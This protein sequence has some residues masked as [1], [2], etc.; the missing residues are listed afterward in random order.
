LSITNVAKSQQH[1]IRF[2]SFRRIPS[3]GQGAVWKIPS[4]GQNRDSKHSIIKK[5]KENGG[6]LHPI[7][8]NPKKAINFAHFFAIAECCPDKFLLFNL[9]KEI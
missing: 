7:V 9:Y 6:N 1:K 3:E 4:E 2:L 5:I 8:Q